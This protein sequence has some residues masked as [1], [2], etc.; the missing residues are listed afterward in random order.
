MKNLE[1]KIY[2]DL[3]TIP[4][5]KRR[6]LLI[7]EMANLTDKNIHCFK[8]TGTCCTMSANSMQITPLEAL[9]ILLSLNISAENAIKFKE[10]MKENIKHYRLDNEIS[11]GKKAHTHLRKTYTCPFFVPG[12]KGCTIKKEL[13]PYGCLGFNP[14]LEEDN[15]SQCHSDFNLLEAREVSHLPNETD[16]NAYIKNLYQLNW[17]KLEIPKAV[18]VLLEHIYP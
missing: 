4:P 5:K 14:R 12:P 3:K 6:E 16:A 18:L 2:D 11:L 7:R 17:N 9:D 15:G 13:K 10:N 1:K 8:C